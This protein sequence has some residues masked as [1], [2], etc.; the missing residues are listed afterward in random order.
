MAT[1]K[2]PSSRVQRRI[3]KQLRDV[4]E[5]RALVTFIL[6]AEKTGIWWHNELA[7]ALT[8]SPIQFVT[9]SCLGTA[10]RKQTVLSDL[11]ETLFF[12]YHWGAC[13]QWLEQLQ[14]LVP[15][16]LSVI[17]P[18]YEPCATWG[19]SA[20]KQ[21]QIEEA[22]ALMCGQASQVT[23]NWCKVVDSA[24]LETSMPTARRETYKEV[25]KSLDPRLLSVE[26]EFF[27]QFGRR[28]PD[29]ALAG[30]P[31]EVALRQLQGYAHDGLLLEHQYPNA[32]VLQWESPHHHK[33]A[34]LRQLR[35][36]HL[37]ALHPF[38]EGR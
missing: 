4:T 21:P 23:P 3:L 29:I 20:D 1:L 15:C 31:G 9:F 37:S 35:S 16:T 28:Y 12:K 32:I 18:S 10:K 26:T 2:E 5:H 34:L 8:S 6:E 17:L 27:R 19:W 33:D 13:Q 7:T 14:Q 24:H 36:T 38:D 25:V 22:C 11:R 30:K